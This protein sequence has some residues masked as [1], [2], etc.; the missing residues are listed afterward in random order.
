[1]NSANAAL[2]SLVG[3][4]L[5]FST[6]ALR[7][8]LQTEQLGHRSGISRVGN[9]DR[10]GQQGLGFDPSALFGSP[11]MRAMCGLMAAPKGGPKTAQLVDQFRQLDQGQIPHSRATS[12]SMPHLPADAPH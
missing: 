7:A 8:F 2:I 12:R 11:R 4:S 6:T 5:S 10:V 1:M 3:S 9:E